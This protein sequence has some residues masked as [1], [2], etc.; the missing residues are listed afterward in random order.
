[1]QLASGRA[2]IITMAVTLAQP[3]EWTL[4]RPLVGTHVPDITFVTS[5]RP[6]STPIA[7]AGKADPLVNHQC[8][9]MAAA[10]ACVESNRSEWRLGRV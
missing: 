9:Q 4:F 1:M 5:L 3:S 2:F 10:S 7:W 6:L 8:L